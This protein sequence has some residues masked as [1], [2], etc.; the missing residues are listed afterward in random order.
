MEPYNPQI[1]GNVTLRIEISEL[2]YVWKM[3]LFEKQ[4]I[5][6]GNWTMSFLIKSKEVIILSLVYAY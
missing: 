4:N 2:C 5:S 6:N 3:L 1:G